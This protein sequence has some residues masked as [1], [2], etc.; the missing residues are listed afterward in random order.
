[1]RRLA[2]L[3][4]LLTLA[5][6]APAS[7]AS[8]VGWGYNGAGQL[9]PGYKSGITPTGVPVLASLLPIK[10]LHPAGA[11]IAL[12]ADGTVIG[13]GGNGQGELA[14]GTRNG[15][16]DAVRIP[17]AEPATQV[18]N[19][20]EHGLALLQDGTVETWGNNIFG[21]LGIGTDGEGKEACRH[22][23]WSLTPV[24]V[25]GIS[26]ARS[27][28]EGG[29]EDAVV[30]NNGTVVAWG[31]DKNGQVGNGVAQTLVHS[32][33][34]VRGLSHVRQVVIGAGATLGGTLYAILE[35]GTVEAL[36]NNSTGQL[37]NGSTVNSLFPVKVAA[38]A[39]VT[40]LSADFTHAMALAGGQLLSWGSNKFGQIGVPTTQTCQHGLMTPCQLTPTPVPLAGA[41]SIATGFADSFAAAG[42]KAYSWGKNAYGKL[43]DGAVEGNRPAPGL[44]SGN[45]PGVTT[46]AAEDTDGFAFFNGPLPKP[47]VEVVAGS[48]S[49]KINWEARAGVQPWYLNWRVVVGRK[50]NG[51]FTPKL[52]LQPAT[53]SYTITGLEPGT[54]YE[55]ALQETQHG[56]F[57]RR[58]AE[59]VPL[60]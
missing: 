46:V 44:V 3:T 54:H 30:L 20:G 51:P 48:R 21:Q 15:K 22:D 17:L 42:G 39:G 24:H 5:V 53:R 41:T 57:G 58:V 35:D 37:G 29:A 9:G 55:V 8:V 18:A 23:C 43:G 50:A 10:E 4:T 2:L 32:P 36:G 60:P 59:G 34:L 25:P 19:A 13:W 56:P 1:M 52:K 12:L 16:V 38:L 40:Q 26:G 7:A 27:V 33:T 28:A 47:G 11:T 6:A 49:L 14:D 31:E 45:L